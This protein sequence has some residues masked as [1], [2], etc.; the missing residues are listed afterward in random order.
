[1]LLL[2]GELLNLAI[3]FDADPIEAVTSATY[4][5]Q[6]VLLLLGVALLLVGLVGLYA[7]LAEGAAGGLGLVGFLVALIGTGLAIGVVWGA[8]FADPALA[9]AAP[10]SF[11]TGPPALVNF[12]VILSFVF[13]G[14][15]WLLFGFAVYRSGSYPRVAAILLM[16]GAVLII[17]PLPFTG[18]IFSVAVAWLGFALLAGIGVSAERTSARVR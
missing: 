18:I 17:I 15:G 1:V 16:V 6:S 9:Q 3:G 14:L 11:E 8:V 10:E 7:H 2:L 13:F 5:V 4:M 12:G